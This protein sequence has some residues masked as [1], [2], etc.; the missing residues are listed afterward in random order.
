MCCFA[1]ELN[2]TTTLELNLKDKGTTESIDLL[3]GTVRETCGISVTTVI[4]MN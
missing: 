4:W 2:L 3:A 1:E